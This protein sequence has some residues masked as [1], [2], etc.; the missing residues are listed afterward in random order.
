MKLQL[1]SLNI[2]N[3]NK[4]LWN[5]FKTFFV[6]RE[7][8]QFLALFMEWF[9]CR[10]MVQKVQKLQNIIELK[11]ILNV[12]PEFSHSMSRKKAQLLLI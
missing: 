6:N 12:L 9:Y 5:E 7:T 4:K 3:Q 10:K 2:H 8:L 11:D 1:F